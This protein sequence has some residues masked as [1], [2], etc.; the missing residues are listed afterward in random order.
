MCVWRK[1]NTVHIKHMDLLHIEDMDS[2]EYKEYWLSRGYAVCHE[3][4]FPFEKWR[5]FPWFY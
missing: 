4:G 2:V 5:A 3:E 1:F